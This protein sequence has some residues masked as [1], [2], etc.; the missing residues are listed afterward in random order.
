[1]DFKSHNERSSVC[2]TALVFV[3]TDDGWVLRPV[4]RA[5]DDEAEAFI[6]LAVDDHIAGLESGSFR[7]R[8]GDRD[9]GGGGAGG[10]GCV[11]PRRAVLRRHG[12]GAAAIHR[13]G[14][15]YRKQQRRCHNLAQ[16]GKK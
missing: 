15:P 6:L 3:L 7:G 8:G 10:R 5:D 11:A 9:S 16:P 2:F 4:Q 1:M 12:A 13:A 14:L